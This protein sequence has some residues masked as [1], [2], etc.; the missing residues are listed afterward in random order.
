MKKILFLATISLFIFWLFVVL[1]N[2]GNL[3]K[4]AIPKAQA[5]YTGNVLLTGT[6]L[7]YIDL[8]FSSGQTISFGN[9]TP[10]LSNAIAKCAAFNTQADVLTSASGGYNLAV[11]DAS[12]TNSAMV[13]SDGSTYIPDITGTI[14]TPLLWTSGVTAGVGIN[15]FSG[16]QKSIAAWGTGTT[17][18]DLSYNKWGKVPSAAAT[19]HT[20]TGYHATADSSYWDWRI[21]VPLTQKTGTY[22]GNVLFTSAAVL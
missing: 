10:G 20:V 1:G 14:A 9:I 19:G 12:D 3:S 5:A 17:V 6:V 2:G 4:G 13:H 7:E 16:T 11:S 8:S 18:C 21:S 22:S 15:L